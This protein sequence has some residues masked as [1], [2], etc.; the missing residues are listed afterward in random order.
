[1]ELRNGFM[2]EPNGRNFI[3]SNTAELKAD[4]TNTRQMRQK[5]NRLQDET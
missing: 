5:Q 1:M 3:A 2:F 4:T